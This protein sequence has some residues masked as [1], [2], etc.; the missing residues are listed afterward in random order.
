M[1]LER[2]AKAGES[3]ATLSGTFKRKRFP[4]GKWPRPSVKMQ[5][6]MEKGP[7][8]EVIVGQPGAEAHPK[9]Q[10]GLA[11]QVAFLGLD[12]VD[13]DDGD[14]AT[15][16]NRMDLERKEMARRLKSIRVDHGIR[17]CLQVR[18]LIRS[19]SGVQIF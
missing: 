4:S 19:Y 14:S 3:A 16:G 5:A 6:W 10:F 13:E 11:I 15:D 18:S 2:A 12:P 17:R 8:T 1:N 7:R 9:A